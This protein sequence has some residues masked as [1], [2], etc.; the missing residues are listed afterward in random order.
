MHRLKSWRIP[1]SF[2]PGEVGITAYGEPLFVA[3]VAQSLNLAL[4][5]PPFSWLTELPHQFVKRTVELT[6][7]EEARKLKKRIFAKPADDKCFPAKVYNSGAE[8]QASALL[9]KNSPVILSDEVTWEFEYRCFVLDRQVVCSS[10]YSRHGELVAD[11]FV[12]AD[13]IVEQRA[14]FLASFLNCENVALPPAVVVDIGMIEGR[15]WAVV[16]A[17]PA[18]GAGIYRCDPAKV[19]PVLARSLMAISQLSAADQAWVIHREELLPPQ[20]SDK[21]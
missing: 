15:G 12:E 10:L 1:D 20:L 4:I 5:E 21:S 3:L 2:T 9:P 7:L 8:I 6:T 11:A 19:L 17:N 18:F 13:S 14:E 16:E